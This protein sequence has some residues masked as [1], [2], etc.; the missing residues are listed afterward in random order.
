MTTAPLH[1]RLLSV[2]VGLPREVEDP[3]R[4]GRRVLTGI[5]KDP[6][7]GPV[8]VGKLG[9]AGDGQADL[10][11][12]GGTYKAVYAYSS[13]NVTFWR[14]EL[15][16]S[17]FGPGSFG[18]NLT[19]VDM[20]DDRVHVGD[21]FRVGAARLRV[22]QPR[23]PCFKLGLK[24]GM[25]D[26]PKRFLASGRIGFYLEV[27]AEGDVAA[28]D[29]VRLESADPAALSI[30]E[31]TQIMHFA[32]KDLAGARRALAVAALSPAWRA[33]LEKRLADAAARQA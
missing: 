6:V 16:R 26:F 33:P 8:R 17:E 28:G 27:L 31:V 2:N 3:A 22:S 29:D 9:L 18:E 13:E 23:Q 4:K 11:A 24:L 10:S 19:V 1:S 7:A 20:P 30:R 5:Y 12:H 21:V 15:G 14:R 32:P 25:P